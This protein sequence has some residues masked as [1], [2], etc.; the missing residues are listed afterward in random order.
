MIRTRVSSIYVNS[1]FV[2]TITKLIIYCQQQTDTKHVAE[3]LNKT[4]KKLQTLFFVL[5]DEQEELRKQIFI[6][7]TSTVRKQMLRNCLIR[8]NRSV[9]HREFQ[10]YLYLL[11]FRNREHAPLN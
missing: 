1:L 8:N 3:K 4:N 6:S 5:I 7:D 11:S 10:V 9:K 2:A